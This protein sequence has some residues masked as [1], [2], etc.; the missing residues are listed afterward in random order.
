MKKLGYIVCIFLSMMAV[1]FAAAPPSDPAPAREA[2]SSRL[3]NLQDADILSIINEVSLETGKNFVVDPRVNGKISLISSKPIRPDEVYNVFLSILELLGYSAVPSGN[4]VKIIPNMES[5]EFATKV[6]TNQSPGRGDEV[7]VRVIPLE[8]V[9]ANQL[10]PVVRPMMPQ[11][12]NISSYTPGNI[13]ILLGRAANLERIVKVIRNIDQS[14]GN[15][16]D[17][18]PLRQASAQQIATVLMNLQNA[19]RSQGE[20]PQVSIAAD[21]RTN[22]I[23]LSGNKSARIHMRLLI[24][25]LDTPRGGRQ[26][27]TEVVYLRY[28]KAKDVAPTLGKVAQ[29]L[30]GKA[31]DN[32]AQ[33]ANV[34]GGKAKEPENLT[35]IQAEPST[36]SLIITAPPA[37]MRALDAVIAKLD[38]KPA[39][40]LVESIVVEIDQ[41]D[42]KD[43]GIL[44]GNT[45]NTTNSNS[46]NS[47]STT[48]TSTSSFI[49]G[50]FGIIPSQNLHAILNALQ[51]KTGVNILSTPSVVVLDNQTGL[52]SVGTN[53]AEQSGSYATTGSTSTVTPFNTVQRANVALTLKVTPQ[54]NLGNAVRLKLGLENDTLQDPENPGL[55]PTINISKIENSVIVNSEDILVLGGLISNTVNEV[56]TKVPIIGDIPVV[57]YL[58][59]SK[60]R[61]AQ[62]KNLM[63]F[64][65]P[66][67]LH[68]AADSEAIT[69]TKYNQMRHIQINGPVDL[70]KPAEQQQ[71]N[72]LPLWKNN[73][74]LPKPFTE[75]S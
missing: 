11:W 27:N 58:F 51:T 65:K 62:R 40:V 1:T 68:T 30:L 15:Q 36:N 56:V 21:E 7:V 66:T 72:I 20:M 13:L 47:D 29:N 24:S 35:S 32:A 64:L 50:I 75:A 26:G 55:N 49:P 19:S 73:V 54:I 38:V 6:A 41:N 14:A 53:I 8:N 57:G 28:L 4:V 74:D 23:L 10:I 52:L 69:Y 42:I 67:I 60:T 3:W 46:S 45:Q 37:I 43:L 63:V 39:Q 12:S 33:P 44:W 70:S 17:V 22:S 71:R 9:S 59:Q 2:N 31:N 48:T 61:R 34:Q 5:G 25:Q 16:I 18:V